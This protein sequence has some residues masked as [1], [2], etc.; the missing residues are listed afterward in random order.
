MVEL[1]VGVLA[2]ICTEKERNVGKV[3]ALTGAALVAA[4]GKARRGAQVDRLPR[5]SAS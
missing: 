5:T 2:I 3:I 1:R 4:T